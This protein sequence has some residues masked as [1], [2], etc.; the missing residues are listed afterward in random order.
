MVIKIANKWCEIV[1]SAS[2]SGELK[3][4]WEKLIKI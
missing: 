4:R 2:F 1:L 3:N